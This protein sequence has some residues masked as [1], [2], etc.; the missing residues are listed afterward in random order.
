[1]TAEVVL[2]VF[3]LLALLAAITGGGITAKEVSIP[4]LE[5]AARGGVGVTGLLCIVGAAVL[6]FLD[7]RGSGAVPEGG[8]IAEG[9]SSSNGEPAG[10]TPLPSGSV[11]ATEG[12]EAPSVSD[13][14][15]LLASLSQDIRD[16]CARSE[17]GLREL[18]TRASL[19]CRLSESIVVDFHWFS[20]SERMGDVF[21]TDVDNADVESTQCTVNDWS[22][23]DTWSLD[24]A[25]ETT[26][27]RLCFFGD[28]DARLVWTYSEDNLFAHAVERNGAQGEL[29][30]WWLDHRDISLPG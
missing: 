8:S 30:E 19:E 14:Q 25:P 11:P 1:M 3:G 15:V 6:I 27:R 24:D 5:G 12:Q 16:H 10:A 26:G 7:A 20:N 2:L 17:F 23:V 4:S 18:G 29:L 13:Q 28:G 9:S 21:D 22:G